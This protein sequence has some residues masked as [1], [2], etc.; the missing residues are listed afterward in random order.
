MNDYELVTAHVTYNDDGNLHRIIVLWKDG[1][2]FRATYSE[3]LPIQGFDYLKEYDK[4]SPELLQ[5][6]AGYGRYITDQMKKDYFKNV[7]KWS[8]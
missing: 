1:I 4:L 2:Y 8:R 6:V 5:R 7:K 3:R